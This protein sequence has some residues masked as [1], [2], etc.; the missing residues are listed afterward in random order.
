MSSNFSGDKRCAATAFV[1]NNKAYVTGGFY[2]DAYL[3]QLSDVQEYNPETDSWTEKIFADGLNLAINGAAAFTYNG[4]GYICYGNKGYAVTYNPVN[5]QVENL[6]DEFNF[7]GSRNYPVSFV[8]EGIP[9]V[10]L[11][12]SGFMT[13]TYHRDFVPLFEGTDIKTPAVNDLY[14]Y[15]N[16]VSKNFHISGITENTNVTL[17]DISGKVVLQLTVAPGEAISVTHLPEGVYIVHA[18]DKVMKMIKQ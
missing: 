7:G 15:P 2:D 6:G 10:G 9:Y 11:G 8:L 16:P 3:V 18:A 5:N 14:V 12:S 13:T 1:I 17:L 4:K